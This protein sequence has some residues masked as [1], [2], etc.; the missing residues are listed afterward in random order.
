MPQQPQAPVGRSEAGS[1]GAN[2]APSSFGPR[3]PH[4]P[5]RLARAGVLG[6]AVPGDVDVPRAV[7]GDRPAAVQPGGLPHQVALR[8]E[9]RPGLVGPRVE[10]RR[11]AERVLRP[12]AVRA[13]PGDVDPPALAQRDLAAAD[14]PDRDRRARLAVDPDRRREAIL[15]RPEPA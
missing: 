5:P 15:A 7:G 3:H 6:P 13:V 2:V 12:G 1:S 4:P 8:L 9:G 11:A 10:H 14:G